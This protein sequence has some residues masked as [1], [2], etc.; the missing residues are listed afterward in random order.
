MVHDVI[1]RVLDGEDFSTG[2]GA[3]GAITGAM[4]AGL[5]AMVSA[6]SLAKNYGLDDS[7][8]IEIKAEA[9]AISQKLVAG[10]QKDVDAFAL[11]KKAYTLPKGTPE[12]IKKRDARIEKGYIEA[13]MVPRDNA[14]LCQRVLELS[15]RLAQKSNPSAVSDLEAAQALA[16]AAVQCCLYNIQINL[17]YIDDEDATRELADSINRLMCN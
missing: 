17:R 3:A 7:Q 6:L 12:E 13:A 11:I 1:K 14:W 2:G 9:A 16:A 5:V 4:A 15:D 10:A 8:Y